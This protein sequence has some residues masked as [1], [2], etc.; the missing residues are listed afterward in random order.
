MTALAPPPSEVSALL[1]AAGRSER[2]GAAKLFLDWQGQP[3]LA[4]AAERVQ[5]FAGEIIVGVAA[6]HEARARAILGPDVAIATGGITRQDTLGRLLSLA[7]HRFLLI[8]DVARPFAS[9]ALFSRVLAECAAH[10]AAVVPCLSIDDRDALAIVEDG[11]MTDALKREEV[12][13]LQT[14]MAMLRAVL[15]QAYEAAAAQGFI[16]DSTPAL[17]HRAGLTVCL[18]DGE[19]KNHK[20]T[21][22]E[23]WP[24]SR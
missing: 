16:E 1:L 11:R 7:Q 9:A 13:R 3:L 12:V 19:P 5:P 24:A 10:E 20:V 6:D 2:F 8:H 14:P 4:H 23:D 18:I 17:L 15:G 22:P 21:Y